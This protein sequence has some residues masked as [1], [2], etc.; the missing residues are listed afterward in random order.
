MASIL[1]PSFWPHEAATWFLLL[2]T[3]FSYR[4]ITNQSIN[5]AKLKPILTLE[6]AVKVL[7]VLIRPS[8]E[9]QYDDDDFSHR[10]QGAWPSCCPNSRQ[11]LSHQHLFRRG[12]YYDLRLFQRKTNQF[13]K[14][15]IPAYASTGEVELTWNLYACKGPTTCII[16][17]V[18]PCHLHVP[19][20]VSTAVSTD[21]VQL[22]RSY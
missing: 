13:F 8:A 2:E 17:T 6:I 14:R 12:F 18:K 7:D 19:P 5:F 4:K 11:F 9:T 3:H 21:N 16:S 20:V 15:L 1:I 10:R 22:Q